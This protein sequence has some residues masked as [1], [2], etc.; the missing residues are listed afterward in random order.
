MFLLLLRVAVSASARNK[1][2][3]LG[4][5]IIVR[6]LPATLQYNYSYCACMHMTDMHNS[7]RDSLP[8]LE[9]TFALVLKLAVATVL[10]VTTV[11]KGSDT[12]EISYAV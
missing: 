5:F 6:L 2:V 3:R 11:A 4:Y 10:T 1:Y 7:S 9:L 8:E 12:A